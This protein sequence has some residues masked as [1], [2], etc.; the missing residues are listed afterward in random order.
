MTVVRGSVAETQFSSPADVGTLLSLPAAVLEAVTDGL[1]LNSTAYEGKDDKG[2][3]V[4]M[5]L[6]TH[7]HTKILT[8][9]RTH[10]HTHT[11]T[12]TPSVCVRMDPA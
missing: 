3:I 6:H 4:R 2:S 1:A 10:T 5:P 9:R 8:H 7:T 11:H 12:H